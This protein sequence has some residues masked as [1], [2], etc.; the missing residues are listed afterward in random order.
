MTEDEN[1]PTEPNLVRHE[2]EV[3]GVSKSWSG[4]GYLRARKRVDNVRERRIVPR[5]REELQFTRVPA[6]ED[7]SG[8][9]ET[10]DDGSISIPV[11]EEELV[12]TKRTVLKERVI[13]SKQT[14]TERER[15][16]ETLRKERVEVEGDRGVD[17][18]DQRGPRTAARA[19]SFFSETRPFF[20][21]S[22]FLAFLVV[23]VGL[24]V[25]TVAGGLSHWQ[26]LALLAGVVV[27]YVVSR[28]FA[29]AYSEGDTWDPRERF[30]ERR[31]RG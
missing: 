24:I 6:V 21:T 25:A 22:E 8:K 7:D 13:V 16:T 10:L 29:K 11:Y 23:I 15:V 17:I 9:I 20:V 19:H 26:G 3:A 18:D 31:A 28:G 14:I 12:V 27:A 4:A 30:G 1:T 2:E 5:E